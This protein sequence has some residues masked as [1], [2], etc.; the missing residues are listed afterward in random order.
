M[1]SI[2]TMRRQLTIAAAIAGATV[3]IGLPTAAVAQEFPTKPIRL[4]VPFAPGGTSEIVA[5]AIAT[6]MSKVLGQN[7]IVENKPG[8]AGTIAMADTLKAPP[9]GYTMILGH[10]GTLAVN[11]YAMAK[12]PYDVNR[13]FQPVSLLARVP[14]L[15]VVHPDVPAKNLKEFVAYA[16]S[17]PG[18]L[19]YGS[20]G[21]A[22]AGHLAYEYLNFVTGIQMVHIP[23]RGTGPQMIDLIAG[24]T[25]TA[26]AGAP[27]LM[28]YI[29][30]GQVRPIAVGMPERIPALPDVPTVAEQGYAGFETSQWYGLIVSSA[31]PKPIVAKLNAAANAALK[32]KAVA[33]RFSRDNAVFGPGTPEDFA[34]FIKA[35]QTRWMGVVKQSGLKID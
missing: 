19:N 22:S 15:F 13:D 17:K 25:D 20:A 6:E 33:D 26:S 35:E 9:D 3:A 14:N 31:V 28:S 2:K 18:R 30:N 34:K 10:V 21:N 8:G 23:Y 1:R 12:Q 5:R 16:K 29:K 11:P 32:T 7:I 4:L 24:R 27:A